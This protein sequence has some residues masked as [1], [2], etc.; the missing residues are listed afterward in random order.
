M[1]ARPARASNGDQT[2]VR[3]F[4][5]STGVPTDVVKM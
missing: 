4:F 3:K 2:R 5:L 1:W